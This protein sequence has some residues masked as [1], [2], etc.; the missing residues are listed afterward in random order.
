MNQLA[1]FRG[2]NMREHIRQSNLIEGVDNPHEDRQS[3]IAWEFLMLEPCITYD[4][5]M[6][7]HDLIMKYQLPKKNRGVY[8]TVSVQV[9]G[10]ICPE[11][12]LAQQMCHNLLYAMQY[13]LR[14]LSPIDTHVR[15][16]L[17][18]PFIDGNGRTG[19]M[20]LWWHEIMNG[21]QPTLFTFED[22]EKYYNL[23]RG[24]KS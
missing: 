23:F 19:R 18:H 11:P 8:R 16:E 20:L 10:R 5:L 9:G 7:L 15:F 21:E 4:V 14:T 17:I 12:F 24:V 2:W 22:R 13:H 1:K 6:D 3:M